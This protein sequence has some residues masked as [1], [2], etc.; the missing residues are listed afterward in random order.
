MTLRVVRVSESV[1]VS[2]RAV[3]GPAA[4]SSAKCTPSAYEMPTTGTVTGPPRPPAKGSVRPGWPSLKMMTAI[5]PAAV[6]LA[7]L[8]ANRQVPR[9]MSA[10]LPAVKPPKSAAS[11]PLV[12]DGSGVAGMVRSTGC[13]TLVTSPAAENW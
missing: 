11:Q 9:W 13:T 7:T 1:C 12:E 2:T 6:A 8:S 5:A 10:M 4:A 3:T